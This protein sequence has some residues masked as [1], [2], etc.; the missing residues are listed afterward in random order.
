MA[1]QARACASVDIF[2]GNIDFYFA[3]A[4]EILKRVI[5]SF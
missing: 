4:F 1:Q 3:T 2:Y 5:F